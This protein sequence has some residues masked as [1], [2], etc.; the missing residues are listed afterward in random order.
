MTHII[1]IHV[2]NQDSIKR[3][4]RYLEITLTKQRPNDNYWL[5]QNDYEKD[6]TYTL[7]TENDAIA[8]F[9]RLGFEGLEGIDILENK[10]I[11]SDESL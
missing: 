7:T 11:S 3:L 9:A 1:K 8:L 2:E 5:L 10:I 6:K 4:E